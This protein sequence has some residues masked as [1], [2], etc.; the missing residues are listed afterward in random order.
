MAPI[1]GSD[2]APLATYK[3]FDAESLT[4]SDGLLL[5]RHRARGSDSPIRLFARR[6]SRRVRR[7]DQGAAGLQDLDLQQEPR[8]PGRGA[9]GFAARGKTDRRRRSKSGRGRQSPRLSVQRRTSRSRFQSSAATISTSATVLSC[10]RAICCCW[11]A[12]SR[13]ARRRHPHPARASL[14]AIKDGARRWAEADRSRSRLS[15]R[16]HGR[17]RYPPHAERRDGPHA[18]FRRQFLADPAQSACCS[19]RWTEKQNAALRRRR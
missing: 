16:Q 18:R 5:R 8:M 13:R 4:E 12:A 2:G 15:D 7:A 3:W 9:E 6:R 1:L 11:S 10:R 17:H 14:A 19:S